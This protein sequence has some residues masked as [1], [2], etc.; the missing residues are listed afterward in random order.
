MY[1]YDS[2]YVA[3]HPQYETS[4]SCCNK[5]FNGQ[6][7][8]DDVC[9]PA[10]DSAKWHISADFS[11]CNNDPAYPAS[12]NDPDLA[13]IY[14][15]E[16][17]VDCCEQFFGDTNCSSIDVCGQITTT[18]KIDTEV[19]LTSSTELSHV[20][21][22]STITTS[23]ESPHELYNCQSSKYHPEPNHS[24]GCSNSLDYPPEW[25][26]LE[27]LFFDSAEECCRFFRPDQSC[28]VDKICEEISSVNSS[29]QEPPEKPKDCVS[30]AWYPDMMVCV[31]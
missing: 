8:P 3:L 7:E 4:S 14:L 2:S 6:C 10:C 18:G 1:P 13:P 19:S 17:L 27:G 20:A 16:S 26:G 5:F 28:K 9:A 11:H 30:N 24:K 31:I 25:E 15:K 29:A 23:T 21:T 22:E 12:W